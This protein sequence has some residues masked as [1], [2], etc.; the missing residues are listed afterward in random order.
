VQLP[1][2]KQRIFIALII[3]ILSVIFSV[4]LLILRRDALQFHTRDYNYFVEQAARLTDPG[5]TK[6]F[7]LQIE[8]YNLLGL[9]GIEGVKNLYHAIHTEYFR[10][11]YVLLYGI[12]QDSFPLFVL[13]S[14]IFYLPILYFA[15]LPLQND[16]NHTL[17]WLLFS[18]LYLTFPATL[19][20][21]TADLRPRVLLGAAW[22][23]A[24][25]AIHFNRPF[26]EKLL[27]FLVLVGIRE[28]GI[29]LGA[30]LIG[31][32][33]IRMQGSRER[34]FQ[35]VLFLLIDIGALLAF[36]AFMRWGGYTR[37]D[38]L[39]NPLSFLRLLLREYLITLS[40]FAVLLGILFWFAW[41]KN[42]K[43]FYSII[44]VLGY[45]MAIVLAGFQWLRDT[46][47]W[48][49]IQ[50]PAT[51]ASSYDIL[52]MAVADYSTA[53]VFYFLILLVVILWDFTRGTWR[54][55]LMAVYTGLIVISTAITVTYYP[56]K[57]M[58]W[59]EN[60]G[61]AQLVWDFVAE[62][63]RY[64][65]RV[66]LDYDTYQAFYNFDQVIVYNRLPLWDTLPEN[67]Y[68]PQNRTALVKQIQSGMDYAVISRES[69]ENILDLSEIA[70]VPARVIASNDRYVVIG[71]TAQ[72]LIKNTN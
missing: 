55:L 17:Q 69:L 60:L 30:I 54:K 16:R 52:I 4:N 2:R 5:L 20:S 39:F 42:Q 32:N 36:L 63:D 68:Y 58:E 37:V 59:R 61:D 1:T 7:V 3:Y 8:G 33:F 47:G 41:K 44:Y 43:Q 72:S 22:C 31:L 11:V 62:H 65:T 13:F 56:P 14:L 18:L 66:L 15:I 67:R 24:V 12:F 10:Y 40:V 70:G 50:R 21:V 6:S 29:F 38:E 27:F 53:L 34:N 48:Y 71:F 49:E 19:N 35:T 26:V 64:D 45:A 28:E 46:F 25:L 9:Q 23:L 51:P 57:L